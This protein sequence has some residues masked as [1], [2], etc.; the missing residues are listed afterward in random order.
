MGM[1]ANLIASIFKAPQSFFDTTPIG[2]ILARFSADMYTIDIE[3]SNVMDFVLFCFLQILVAMATIIFVTPFFAVAIIPLIWMYVSYMNYFRSVSRE[4]KRLESVSRSPIYAQFSETLGGL[5]T[6][7]AYDQAKRFMD[8]FEKKVDK[9]TRASYS[10]KTADR[11][12]ATRLE[13]IGATITGLAALLATNLA[14]NG[15]GS[16]SLAGLSLTYAIGITGLLSFGTRSFAQ[17][18]STMNSAERVLHYTEEIPHEAPYTSE[19]LQDEIDEDNNKKKKHPKKD[20]DDDK[21][22]LSKIPPSTFAVV[23]SGGKV[24]DKS[25]S[26][27]EKGAIELKNLKM[28]YRSETPLVLRGLN[29]TIQGGNRVGVVGRT[30]SGKSSLFLTLLR[31]VEPDVVDMITQE[32]GREA[33]EEQ[34]KDEEDPSSYVAPISID[35]VDTLRIGLTELRS[36]IA[37]IPQNP[38]LFSGTIRSNIDPFD[39]YSDDE[40]WK[41]LDGCGMKDN[42]EGMPGLLQAEVAEYGENLSAG[43]R[44]LLVLGRALLKQ[45]KILLLDEATSSVDYETDKEIQRTIREAFVDCTVLTIAHRINTILDSDKILVMKDG[46]VDEYEA[47]DVLLADTSS[48]FFDIVQHAKTSEQKEQEQEEGKE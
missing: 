13:S 10:I 29:L 23:Q 20:N 15:S 33:G 27:P 1:H 28:R 16:A 34:K 5:T 41:A 3:L 47:P 31:L 19:E 17:L 4:T 37:I 12:L 18:E 14:M 42:V 35:G 26:W 38:V 46:L 30:G 39:D 25:T 40:V 7:R 43:M 36:K 24:S 48:T 11:W 6:I 9:N 22:E 44:Q 21:D 2:R 8:E 45:C 32:H